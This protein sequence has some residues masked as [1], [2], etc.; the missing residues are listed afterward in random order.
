[1]TT[2]PQQ[3][4]LDA[5]LANHAWHQEFD[6]VGGYPGSE[7]EQQ[8]LEA[9][10]K[11]QASQQAQPAYAPNDQYEP[12]PPHSETRIVSTEQ[13]GPWRFNGR[14]LYSDEFE[15]D[16]CLKLDGDFVSDEQ[17]TSFLESMCAKLN[18]PQAQP[19]QAAQQ[20]TDGAWLPLFLNDDAAC[21]SQNAES[22][23]QPSL[24]LTDATQGAAAPALVGLDEMSKAAVYNKWDHKPGASSADLMDM[25]VAEFCRI[26]N[27]T[28]PGASTERSHEQPQE[29]NQTQEAQGLKKRTN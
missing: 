5:L 29:K 6:D 28:A 22:D 18:A 24:S 7:L 8:N 21:H 20:I 25:A 14:V 4:A 9:I 3:A 23:P 15:T 17:R 2:T 27:L 10:A 1:M 12:K 19:E 16:A 13:L 26:N 11:L